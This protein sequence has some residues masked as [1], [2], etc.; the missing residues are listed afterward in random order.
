M[1]TIQ[2]NDNITMHYIPMPKIKTTTIGVYVHQELNEQNATKNAILPYILKRAN[3]TY[4]TSEQ[5]AHALEDLYGA[6]IGAG[7]MKKGVDQIMVFDGETISDKYAPGNETLVADLVSIL[8][9]CVFSPALSGGGFKPEYVM[10]EKINLKDRIASLINDKRSYAVTRCTQEMCKD[11]AFKTSRLGRIEDID[12]L[13][14][15]MLYTYYQTIMT[16]SPI[17]IY[18]CGDT[19]IELVEREVRSCIKNLKFTESQIIKNEILT[20][21][22][23]EV[24]TVEEKMDVSQGKLAMGFRTNIAPSD[25]KYWGLMVGNSILGGGAHSKLFNN[26]REKLSLA[27]YAS[28]QLE[29]FKGIMIVN[30]GIEFEKFTATY[31]ETL[32]QIDALK[33]GDISELEFESSMNAILNALDSYYD[34]PH[35]M[36]SF[37]LNEAVVGTGYD[38]EFV[39]EK[40]KSVTIQDVVEAS[41]CIQLDTVY[42]LKGKEA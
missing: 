30:A 29:K 27:Y 22:S 19:D 10:Q 26:V 42:F 28:S 2:I 5:L 34:D 35:Y 8:L 17:H 40:V 37:Y 6:S 4:P 9:S 15:K 14:E 36:Q 11:D 39:K 1:Q 13:D 3:A 38:I 12:K 18:V 20:K 21:Q 41:K 32:V 23:D 31:D 33:N 24:Q 7:I 25:E 16:S